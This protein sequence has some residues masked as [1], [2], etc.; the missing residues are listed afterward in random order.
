MLFIM[1][2]TLGAFSED[3]L[4]EYIVTHKPEFMLPSTEVM[5]KI[6]SI[7]RPTGLS[8]GIPEIGIP[9]WGNIGLN[10]H[11]SGIQVNEL[12][13]SVG[14]GWSLEAGGVITRVVRGLPDDMQI[15]GY[16]NFTDELKTLFN[17]STN[18]Y[19]ETSAY[20]LNKIGDD[21]DSSPDIY[22]YNFYGY[23]GKFVFTPGGEIV[24][25][26]K[27]NL[28]ITPIRSEAGT[29][30][31]FIVRA[32]GTSFRFN[33]KE[34]ITVNSCNVDL[35]YTEYYSAWHLGNF[36]SQRTDGTGLEYETVYSTFDRDLYEFEYYNELGNQVNSTVTA[37]LTIEKRQLKSI[38]TSTSVAVFSYGE[39]EELDSIKILG[40]IPDSTH[41]EAS[42]VRDIV[43]EYGDFASQSLNPKR[44]RK[45][46]SVKIGSYNEDDDQGVFD[47]YSLI[48]NSN[49]IPSEDSKEQDLWGYYNA[50]LESSLIPNLD[51][52]Y[53][54]L[55]LDFNLIELHGVNRRID[56][57]SMQ[58][59]ILKSIENPA[60]GIIEYEYE[61]QSFNYMGAGEI[62]GGGLRI[63]SIKTDDPDSEFAE[64]VINYNY[65][66]S[67]GNC[68]G[69][70]LSKPV[71]AYNLLFNPSSTNL[72]KLT[73]RYANYAHGF[74]PMFGNP[75]YYSQVKTETIGL[76][77]SISDFELTYPKEYFLTGSPELTALGYSSLTDYYN[78]GNDFNVEPGGIKTRISFLGADYLNEFNYELNNTY[79]NKVRTFDMSDN[80]IKEIKYF[81]NYRGHNLVYGFYTSPYEKY[82]ERYN[83]SSTRTLK[84][85]VYPSTYKALVKK[86]ETNYVNG[87][88]FANTT[89]Y[90][91]S[92]YIS[93]NVINYMDWV[94][95]HGVT[96][97]R[98]IKYPQ[99]YSFNPSYVGAYLEAI[100][101][102]DIQYVDV[103]FANKDFYKETLNSHMLYFMKS[104]LQQED[105]LADDETIKSADQ[106]VVALSN[107]LYRRYHNTPIE[108]VDGIID[109]EGK[110]KIIQAKLNTYKKLDNEEIVLSEE[111]ILQGPINYTE[112]FLSKIETDI[113]SKPILIK[114]SGYQLVKRY[115][116]DGLSG[117][118][119]KEYD[120]TGIETS[121]EWSKHG[122]YLKSKTVN[123]TFTTN[124][125][126]H[127]SGNLT[128]ETDMLGRSTYYVYDTNGNLI[129]KKDQDENIRE[130][131]L[132]NMVNREGNV[133]INEETDL[134]GGINDEVVP[135]AT[136]SFMDN[137]Y[138]FGYD[139]T[140]NSF[141][142]VFQYEIDYGDNTIEEISNESFIH[143]YSQA[144]VYNVK[145]KEK[146]NGYTVTEDKF[147]VEINTE[148]FTPS[149]EFT[150]A[151][152]MILQDGNMTTNSLKAE[153]SISNLNRTYQ[154]SWTVVNSQNSSLSFND[155]DVIFHGKS[156]IV[157]VTQDGS[158]TLSCVISD[159]IT[160]YTN[161]WNIVVDS[162]L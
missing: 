120:A 23:K 43:F 16:L 109:L 140:I 65:T 100:S 84:R 64:S 134:S 58:S 32:N 161:S 18:E 139:F 70:L 48:Y 144:G 33:V 129:A 127:P 87:I 66:N 29:L 45:L 17:S 152:G 101:A 63:K 75:I 25:I 115:E 6:K 14:L 54:C 94:D 10:Y 125:K 104:N 128:K 96:H 83:W 124:Y 92:N 34:K 26:P 72:D 78:S 4:P 81:Y 123:S 71:F 82:T 21:Y 86:E 160:E 118:L 38:S 52:Y 77:Y 154:V 119:S 99:D 159:G 133:K 41:V 30:L 95:S 106:N 158:Y 57:I 35:G 105:I 13:S 157:E 85:F 42:K 147:S 136:L 69:V 40:I 60:G 103:L 53:D 3:L 145:L 11:A 9:L 74:I 148:S 155:V 113:D 27:S 12:A 36:K 116:Y 142:P 153:V 56:F 80:L 7:V 31:E 112:D 15:K 93:S 55:D 126:Y 150:D 79:L 141:N 117:N 132:S 89:N 138:T 137:I 2:G 76:G 135:D 107:M 20:L 59:G 91:Y 88:P 110:R 61:P 149:F 50:N 46:T 44:I 37:N 1:L 162:A 111:F 22:Y 62:T 19:V 28:E 114:N 90:G 24:T 73:Y 97:F 108:I 67:D 130:Y 49:E 121:Y 122:D 68:T 143:V 102:D 39:S 146:K 51:N 131:Y 156:A 47:V 151:N 8:T 98:E 5:S